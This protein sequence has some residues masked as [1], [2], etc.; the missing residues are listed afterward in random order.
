MVESTSA[1]PSVPNNKA[2]IYCRIR[3]AVFDGSGHDQNGEAVAKSMSAWNDTSITLNTQYMF[4]KGANSYKFPTKVFAPEASQTD[5]YNE[6][7]PLVNEFTSIPGR[8]V[9]LLAYGQTGTGKTHTIFGAKEESLEGIEHLSEWGIFPKVVNSVLETM[10]S[11]G[12]KFKLFIAGLEFYLMG[13]F[14]LLDKNVPVAVAQTGP[15]QST[16]VEIKEIDDLRGVMET[17]YKNRTSAGTK[18]NVK[19]RSHD[20]SS[21]SHA[22]MILTLWQE[23]E[24]NFQKSQFH[25][26]DLAGAERPDKTGAGRTSGYEIMIKMIK[27]EKPNVG[28]Q[29][30]LINYELTELLTCITAATEAHK[31]GKKFS[32]ATSLTPPAIQYLSQLINGSCIMNM[33]ICLSQAP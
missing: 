33:I 26:I 12:S 10:K 1:K 3:P 28:D 9:C 13:C 5:V 11:T 2:S 29:G 21:R 4:S 30:C 8:N 18:M 20:G 31:K 32:V 19:I 15:R 27:H 25:L 23:R 22:A 16:Q 24:G 6:F 17:I 14:D 7:E